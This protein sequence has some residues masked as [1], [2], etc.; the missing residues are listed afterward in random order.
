MRSLS[1]RT[2]LPIWVRVA[3]AATS[4]EIEECEGTTVRTVSRCE[5]NEILGP[6]RGRT[7]KAR[8]CAREGTARFL[9]FFVCSEHLGDTGQHW[10]LFARNNHLYAVNPNAPVSEG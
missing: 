6:D 7:D 9:R 4:H 2:D 1:A 10:E 5:V 8:S 3:R